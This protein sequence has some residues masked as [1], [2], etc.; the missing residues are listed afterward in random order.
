MP[1]VPYKWVGDAAEPADIKVD[2]EAED[3]DP[4]MK[5]LI[6]IKSIHKFLVEI[7][8]KGIGETT[9]EKIYDQ[10]FTDVGQFIHLEADD[11][12]FLGPNVSKKMIKSIQDALMSIT[13]PKL[14]AASK[15]FGRGLGT[16]K[17]S[18]VVQSNS[19]FLVERLTKEEYV[20]LLLG[21]EGFAKKTAELAAENMLDFWAF[22][23]DIIPTDT[24]EA[25]IN[26]TIALYQQSETGHSDINGKKFCLTGFRDKT[27]TDFI[28]TNGGIIQNG[29]NG[30]TNVLIRSSSSYTNKKTE[31]A[32]SKPSIELVEQDVFKEK[33]GL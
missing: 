7:G 10:G 32:E 28:T 11:I 25:I 20:R 1:K 16:K 6:S 18:K 3:A 29:C 33:Y 19:E 22:V 2:H 24:Y 12:A 8:A 5:R 15:V 9:V 30:S 13:V 26:N 31:F 4:D 14:M 21:V 23:D 27:I 17:F